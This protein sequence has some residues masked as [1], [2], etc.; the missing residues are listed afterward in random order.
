MNGVHHDWHLLL[1]SLIKSL[2][3]SPSSSGVALGGGGSGNGTRP[4]KKERALDKLAALLRDSLA[5]PSL[6]KIEQSD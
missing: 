6:N 2:H 3:L 4:T 1:L 5:T